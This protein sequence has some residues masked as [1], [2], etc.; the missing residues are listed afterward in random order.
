[1]A[2]V[3]ICSDYGT[4]E[5]KICHSTFSPSICQEVVGPDTMI[6]VFQMFSFV[7]VCS[8]AF[9][10]FREL[11]NHNPYQNIVVTLKGHSLSI[12]QLLLIFPFPS[13]GN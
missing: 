6:L 12:K 11:G 4:Q 13:H 3:T 5:N 10:M 2:T 7:L 9:N 8:V 1:M